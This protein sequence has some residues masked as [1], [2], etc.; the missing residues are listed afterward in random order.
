MF[1]LYFRLPFAMNT[2]DMGMWN[3][4]RPEQQFIRM[5][6]ITLLIIRR[7]TS[8]I[9]PIKP[10]L[11]PFYFLPVFP[12][13]KPEH[14]LGRTGTRQC[15]MERRDSPHIHLFYQLFCHCT[16]SI[17]SRT[18]YFKSH[19]FI[20]IVLNFLGGTSAQNYIPRQYSQFMNF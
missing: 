3:I 6:E 11:L 17:F 20:F 1:G 13:P 2:M 9:H 7:N 8:L 5:F 4:Q 12:N 15:Q 19:L 16:Q 18:Q 14:L 10:Q